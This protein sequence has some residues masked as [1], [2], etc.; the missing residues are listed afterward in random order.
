MAFQLAGKATREAL[1]LSAFPITDLPRMVVGA[2]VVSAAVTLLLARAMGRH[3]PG[4]LI[5]ALAGVSGLGLL[6]EWGL[7]RAAPAAAAILYY[8]HFSALGAV[9]ISGL[10]TLVTERFDPREARRRLGPI[11][12]GASAGGLVGGAAAAPLGAWLP[13]SGLLPL[14][15]LLHLAAAP[16]L[17]QLGAGPPVP[18]PS[19][20]G[21][22][23]GPLATLGGSSYLR[24][25]AALAAL[26]ALAEGLLDWVFK[27]RAVDAIGDGT[28]LLRFF[29]L[30]YTAT[31]LVGILVQGGVLR[32]L[33]A[34]L[35][36]GL[37]AAAQPLGVLLGSIAGLLLPGLWPVTLARGGE[38]VL[39]TS[40]FRGAGEL[41]FSPV[42]PRAKHAT[43]LLVD[44]GA[45]RLGDVVGGLLLQ[46]MLVVGV[47]RVPGRMLLPTAAAATIAILVALR[48][49]RDYPAALAAGLAARAEGGREPMESRS[50]AMLET[51]GGYELPSRA[52]R[53]G[54]PDP[55]PSEPVEEP[56]GPAWESRDAGRIRAALEGI[57]LGRGEVD[58]VVALVGWD[59]VAPAAMAALARVSVREAGRLAAR[60]LDPAEHFAI[61]RRLVRVLAEARSPEVPGAL[62]RGLDDARFEVRYL[63]ARAL[64]RQVALGAPPPPRERVLAVVAREVAVGR[65]L[66]EGRQLLD[67]AEDLASP[68]AMGVLRARADR[69]LEHV[70]TLLAL[71]L[72]RGPVR[73]ACHALHTTDA[74]L[75]GTALEYLE[76]VL[77]PEIRDGLWPFLEPETAPRRESGRAEEVLDRLLR[78]QE[79]IARAL[80]AR[81]QKP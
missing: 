32:G 41:L 70:F 79:S 61:R 35:G 39:R 44:V 52:T 36:P 7:S 2:A 14:L 5:P 6:L 71:V 21:A 54:A 64:H 68:M 76:N 58:P 10:W 8:L 29:S 18:S 45:A 30:F 22:E 47:A 73:L 78:S 63:A 17:L 43:K 72:P 3:G 50:L 1:F 66:W 56:S 65:P 12:A 20:A 80:E 16:L 23:P 27:A 60:M 62:L 28:A 34:R 48:L 11:M 77:P 55:A 38:I 33:I 81:A 46:M 37:A 49:R 13:V 67:E 24:R 74:Q 26:A 40:L 59:E 53:T 31:A 4:P 69:S 51:V 15:A 42:A 19:G 9:L 25:L 57:V 75:R